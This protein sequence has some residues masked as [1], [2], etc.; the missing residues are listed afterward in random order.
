[1]IQGY[2]AVLGSI[3]LIALRIISLKEAFLRLIGM[4]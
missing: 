1:M 3:L 4:S 2:I